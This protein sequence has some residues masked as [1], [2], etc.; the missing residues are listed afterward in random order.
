MSLIS[1]EII[2]FATNMNLSNNVKKTILQLWHIRHSWGF[3][4]QSPFAFNL[5]RDVINQTL[6]Y[7]AYSALHN[8][9]KAKTGASM[10]NSEGV[11]QLFL[12]LANFI[13]PQIILLP[14]E[15][16]G[17]SARYMLAACPKAS[18][19]Q[20][21]G[22]RSLLQELEGT[23]RIDLL[24]LNVRTLNE[25]LAEVIT[26]MSDRSLIVVS[27]INESRETKQMW[28]DMVQSDSTGVTFNLKRL[29]LIFNDRRLTPENHTIFFPYY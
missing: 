4:L 13:Q 11:D 25:M 7:Y 21:S 17:M 29:G 5:E 8:E 22:L 14:Q 23:P 2:N 26:Y 3:G 1:P 10:L 27:G 24:C 16:W 20:F 19:L 12:R 9:R 15:E 6:P 18:L 28:E